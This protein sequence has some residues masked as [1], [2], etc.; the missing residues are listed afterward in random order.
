MPSWVCVDSSVVLTLYLPQPLRPNARALWVSWAAQ[1]YQLTAP[2][3]FLYEATS[4]CRKS[5]HQGV[6]PAIRGAEILRE[7]LDLP[8]DFSTPP[9]LHA[10]AYELATRFNLPT[11]YDAN[12]LVVAQTLGCEFWTADRRLVNA[13]GETLPWVKWLGSYPPPADEAPPT[14]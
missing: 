10:R 11:A 12:Y 6:I 9:E 3:L 5:V 2:P 13:V 8:I 4:I 7:I 1:E 14:T